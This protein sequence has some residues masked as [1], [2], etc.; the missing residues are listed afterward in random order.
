MRPLCASLVVFLLWYV[1]EV[2]LQKFP[3]VFFMGRTLANHSYVD[4]SLVGS[5]GS[6]SVQCRT[7]LNTCCSD[8]EGKHRGDWRFPNGTK[9]EFSNTIIIYER[10]IK[11]EVHMRRS[12][13]ATSPLG[14]YR[15]DIPTVAVHHDTDTSVRDTVYVGLYTGSTGIIII[16][17]GILTSDLLAG[18]VTLAGHI[19]LTVKT[20][21][22]VTLTCVSVDGPATTVTWTRNSVKIKGEQNETV[23]NDP[24]T[25]EYTHTLSVT[26]MPNIVSIFSCN[27][28]N[29]KPS[30]STASISVFVQA[31]RVVA[32]TPSSANIIAGN[33]FVLNCTI[34]PDEDHPYQ[35]LVPDSAQNINRTGNLLCFS[36]INTSQAGEYTCSVDS[37]SIAYNVIVQS[38]CYFHPSVV[39]CVLSL[40]SSSD[41]CFNQP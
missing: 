19:S 22:A 1:G 16:F 35:W 3:N 6:D 14:I 38:K 8:T 25:A 24:E 23:F 30:F 5:D 31:D 41:C 21:F 11:Q 36:P 4:L 37:A 32:I 26:V 29:N 40:C 27:V 28:S 33:D 10:R 39:T 2:Y 13:N 18:D 34:W 7:D 20:S 9:L 12:N 15:C 17:N